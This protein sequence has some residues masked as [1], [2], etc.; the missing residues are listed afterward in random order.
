MTD[1]RVQQPKVKGCCYPQL[2]AGF[3]L[4]AKLSAEF[5]WLLCDRFCLRAHFGWSYRH[6][7]RACFGCWRLS[8]AVCGAP[9]SLPDPSEASSAATSAD[10]NPP[11]PKK[12]R[13]LE[14][15]SS[16]PLSTVLSLDKVCRARSRSACVVVSDH[17]LRAA[18]CVQV[19]AAVNSLLA[20]GSATNTLTPSVITPHALVS[21]HVGVKFPGFAPFCPLTTFL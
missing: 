17:S 8:S 4:Q 18:S 2:D 13:G 19:N 20:P 5:T 16:P 10:P 12:P 11:K 9:V 14:L 1:F 3:L 21:L 6:G 7:Y 15:P